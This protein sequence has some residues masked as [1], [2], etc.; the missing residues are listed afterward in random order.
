MKQPTSFKNMA[1]PPSSLS[2]RHLNLSNQNATNPFVVKSLGS[3]PFATLTHLVI[4][5]RVALA[6]VMK[7]LYVSSLA[8]SARKALNK[9]F[10]RWLMSCAPS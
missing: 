2:S 7:L 5:A 3:V 8:N 4:I 1:L 10:K 9:L 6:T